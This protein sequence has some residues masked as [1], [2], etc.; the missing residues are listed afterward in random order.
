MFKK[1]SAL[2]LVAATL[3]TSS[4][5]MAKESLIERINQKGVITVGTEGKAVN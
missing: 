3:A 1:I 4:L 2:T 5:A